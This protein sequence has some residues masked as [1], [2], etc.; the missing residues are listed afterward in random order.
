MYQIGVQCDNFCMFK[1][2][3]TYHVME[4]KRYEGYLRRFPRI[5]DISAECQSIT[6]IATE[7]EE[8]KRR[9]SLEILF[10]AIIE[11]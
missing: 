4:V 11:R 9:E 1:Q 8:M 7:D 5:S 3:Y 10:Y 2:N 6:H